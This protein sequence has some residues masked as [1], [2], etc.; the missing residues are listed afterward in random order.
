MNRSVFLVLLL[1]ILQ[2]HSISYNG[3]RDSWARY[4]QWNLCPDQHRAELK[5]RL[6]TTQMDGLV[7]YMVDPGNTDFILVK[8]EGGKLFIEYRFSSDT[9]TTSFHHP[10]R[11]V[12]NGEAQGISISRERMRLRLAIGANVGSTAQQPANSGSDLCFGECPRD[13]AARTS[14]NMLFFGGVPAGYSTLATAPG[15]FIGD[16]YDIEYKNCDC[17]FTNPFVEQLGPALT[18]SAKLTDNCFNKTADPSSAAGCV[19]RSSELGCDC[20][21]ECT[22]VNCPTGKCLPIRFSVFLLLG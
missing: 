1:C 18:T 14:S 17:Y 12:A 22:D 11:I 2:V 19:C 21:Y 13:G 10:D 6:K 3:T 16:I 7:M 9:E 20:I 15:N 5:F 8:L 4:T